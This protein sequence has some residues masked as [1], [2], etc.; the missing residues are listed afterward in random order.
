M[1]GQPF[2]RGFRYCATELPTHINYR[3]GYQMR[4]IPLTQGQFAL[5][6]DHDYEQ[7]NK[8]NWYADWD[9]KVRGGSFYVARGVKVD[10]KRKT[11]YMHR[12]IV[13]AQKGQM[14]D[15]INGNTLDN[16]RSNLRLATNAENQRN[17][18]LQAN[19][20]SGAP[21]V[22]FD[23]KMKRWKVSIK[24][25]GKLVLVGVSADKNEALTLRKNAE[26][27]HRFHENNGL[28]IS[29]KQR[30]DFQPQPKRRPQ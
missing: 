25:N 22:Y 9:A 19:N 27:R 26:Q 6:D 18:K 16:R 21:G 30:P 15:H 4:Q 14:V 12:E 10:G 13:G 3:T 29:Q 5:V 7:L 23:A 11:I 8:F 20:T 24:L 2:A 17:R 1:S 28:I